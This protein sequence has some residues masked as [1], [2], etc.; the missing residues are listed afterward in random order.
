MENKLIGC[1]V[2]VNSAL[3]RILQSS[4]LPK[5]AKFHD[6]WVAL[7]AAAFGKIGYVSE[8]TLLYRQH[9]DNLVGG[10][11]Y[12]SYLKNRISLLQKQKD[13]I[14]AL[15]RQ[16]EEFLSLYSAILPESKREMIQN[17]ANLNQFGFL[18]RRKMILSYRY[19]KTGLIRNV[20][21]L[22]II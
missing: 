2:M 11:G 9:G 10:T 6:W 15:E 1:T 18:K 21:L 8:S 19:L 20:G 12:T 17:F 13:A 16:A 4:H 22:I 3:R 7:I 14:L 5:E